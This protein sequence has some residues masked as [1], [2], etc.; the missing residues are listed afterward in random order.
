MAQYEIAIIGKWS[1][2]GTEEHSDIEVA[3]DATIRTALDK[4][5]EGRFG[6]NPQVAECGVIEVDS[7]E[8]R[9]FTV[10]LSIVDLI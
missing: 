3:R 1:F 4:M 2:G 10:S 9:T 8:E 7:G 6:S 5:L